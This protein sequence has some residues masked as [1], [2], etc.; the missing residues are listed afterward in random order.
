[1]QA[2]CFS[3]AIRSDVS[4][5]TRRGLFRG[6]GSEKLIWGNLQIFAVKDIGMS[7]VIVIVAVAF[8]AAVIVTCLH[9]A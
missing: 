6:A 5:L 1:M 2:I 7:A 8:A 3:A 9:C 4:L